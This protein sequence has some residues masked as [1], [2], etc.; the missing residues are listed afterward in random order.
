M[1]V[2]HQFCSSA[3]L[4]KLLFIDGREISCRTPCKKSHLAPKNQGEFKIA[5]RNFLIFKVYDC[6]MSPLLATQRMKR[7]P[8]FRRID[9]SLQVLPAPPTVVIPHD[10]WG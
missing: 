2:R 9:K 1:S 8:H 5:V 3:R 10:M 4:V 7:S 6:H